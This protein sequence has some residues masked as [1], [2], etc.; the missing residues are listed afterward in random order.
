MPEKPIV[1]VRDMPHWTVWEPSISADFVSRWTTDVWYKI[2]VRLRSPPRYICR[3]INLGPR[4][5]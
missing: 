5:G 2:F 4:H 1:S 3:T